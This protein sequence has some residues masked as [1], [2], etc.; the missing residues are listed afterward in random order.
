MITFIIIVVIIILIAWS[1]VFDLD[2]DNSDNNNQSFKDEL[3]SKGHNKNY[4]KYTAQIY[5]DIFVSEPFNGKY[6]ILKVA[7]NN[8]ATIDVVDFPPHKSEKNQLLLEM[9]NRLY[10]RP[11]QNL[12]DDLGIFKISDNKI[13]IYLAVK[14]FYHDV[15]EPPLNYNS[16]EGVIKGKTL[17][18]D[19]KEKYYD[20]ASK[21]SKIR[22]EKERIVFNQL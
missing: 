13:K 17:I 5:F 20:Q 18:L 2:S 8:F 9:D 11:E 14:E 15:N 12:S 4:N 3:I 19:L 10:D 1:G 6:I 21:S 22:V 16:F 7:E